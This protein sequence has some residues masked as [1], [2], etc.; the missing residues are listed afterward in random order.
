MRLVS[1]V[2][3]KGFKI[4]CMMSRL[5]WLQ[6]CRNETI[7][8]GSMYFALEVNDQKIVVCNE[9]TS[10]AYHL[11]I[12]SLGICSSIEVAMFCDY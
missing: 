3:K 9:L 2:A 10:L 1:Q 8:G 11:S 5:A 12:R 6:A 7:R 4:T